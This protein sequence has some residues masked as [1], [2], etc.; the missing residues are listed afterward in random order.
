MI[1]VLMCCLSFSLPYMETKA[2]DDTEVKQ[3]EIQPKGQYL[4]S[5]T[6]SIAEA[7]KGKIYVSGNTIAQRRVSTVKVAVIVEQKEEVTGIIIIHGRHKNI[8]IMRSLQERL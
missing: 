2:A 5:G 8:M 1:A 3:T 7:G 4:Q 6:S